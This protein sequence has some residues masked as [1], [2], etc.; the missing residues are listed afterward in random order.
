GGYHVYRG[1]TAGFVPNAGNLVSA[2]AD[3]GFVDAGMSGGYYKI[4]AL[5][6]HGNESAFV[7]VSPGGVVGVPGPTVAALALAGPSP[8]P[9]RGTVDLSFTLS[10]PGEA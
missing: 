6:V 2:Q 4:S 1:T 8:N 9:S 5:D 10:R 7:L 3:T